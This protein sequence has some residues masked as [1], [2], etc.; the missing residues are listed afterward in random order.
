MHELEKYL[1]RVT[2]EVAK[3]SRTSKWRCLPTHNL[4]LPKACSLK[5]LIIKKPA[6]TVHP[7]PRYH[8]PERTD[9]KIPYVH[10]S[11]N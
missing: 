1:T 3:H 8:A 7:I 11:F 10:K 6:K 9:T 4:D 5:I 2:I